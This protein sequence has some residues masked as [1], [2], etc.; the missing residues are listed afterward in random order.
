ME[1]RVLVLRLL[2]QIVF[3]F[4]Q[5]LLPILELM[6]PSLLQYILQSLLEP[7]NGT[8]A[9]LELLYL[10][11][12][13][14]TLLQAILTSGL[15]DCLRSE[16]NLPLLDDLRR[17]VTL[18]ARNLEGDNK[19]AARYA[20]ANL[21][22][23]SQAWAAGPDVGAT[24]APNR[25]GANGNGAHGINDGAAASA[26]RIP[27]FDA[28]LLSDFHGQCWTVLLDPSLTPS[29]DA[30]ARLVLGEI[31]ALMLVIYAKTG[32]AMVQAL[33]EHA[34]GLQQQYGLDLS[35][36][37]QALASQERKAV[38]MSLRDMLKRLGR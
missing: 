9:E 14:M 25:N 19:L 15:Q 18:I 29:S 4:K 30:Q 10:R 38:T 23:M 34:A 11:R 28:L 31:A 21:K 12:E 26:S 7:V 32:N 33:Q 8:D 3:A 1:E 36:L 13:Y 6:W 17:S 16:R 35:D 2:Q 5:E 24:S 27:G 22:A 20:F 37:L